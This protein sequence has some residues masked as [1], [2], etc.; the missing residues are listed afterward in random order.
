VPTLHISLKFVAVRTASI[1]Y[2]TPR[3]MAELE[4]Y[5]FST[6]DAGSSDVTNSEAGQIRVGG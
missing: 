6:G 3:T 5:D 1:F 4:D 2:W